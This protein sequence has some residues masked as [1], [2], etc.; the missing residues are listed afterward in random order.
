MTEEQQHS[1][2][3]DDKDKISRS[4]RK[5][6]RA[7]LPLLLRK[8]EDNSLAVKG[9]A[10]GFEIIADEAYQTRGI[11]INELSERGSQYLQVEKKLRI[12]L[13]MMS[14]KIEFE[15]SILKIG[16]NFIILS[17][18]S[19][20]TR[21]ERRSNLRIPTN[22]YSQAFIKTS[23]WDPTRDLISP[24][25]FQIHEPIGALINVANIS[26]GGVGLSTFFPSI[27]EQIQLHAVDKTAQLILPMQG[28]Q[29]VGLKIKWIKSLRKTA[30]SGNRVH[31]RTEYNIGCEFFDVSESALSSIKIF[32]QRFSDDHGI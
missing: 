3:I 11:F 1:I 13:T 2:H 10:A 27:K 29:Q 21:F 19:I 6:C 20:L 26:V 28:P 22:L 12:E 31:F 9:K 17:L 18:P 23:L 32:I 14:M 5:I 30:A 4:L 7:N 24:P 25:F 16:K 8:L 15:S